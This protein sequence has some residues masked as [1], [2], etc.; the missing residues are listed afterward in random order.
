MQPGTYI[1]VNLTNKT[2]ITN[3]DLG[4]VGWRKV[5]SRNQ[6]W[7]IQNSGEGYR[8]KNVA[9]GGYLAVAST[10]DQNCDLY[11]SGYP[12]TWALVS[13]P[14]HK[15]HG[16]YG[17]M[18]GDTDRI[19]DLSDGADGTKIYAFSH[20]LHKGSTGHRVWIFE[21]VNDEAG[22]DRLFA[23]DRR[24]GE[25]ESLSNLS[26]LNQKVT[27]L[28]SQVERLELLLAELRDSQRLPNNMT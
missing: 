3:N 5:D 15:G 9:S 17:V 16:L 24:L 25:A 8:F 6:Q 20:S 10:V 19:L 26:E 18:M 7:F 4:V 12:T 1:I 21:R 14:E 13:N 23:T 22:D 28:T 27:R 2:A 11:C